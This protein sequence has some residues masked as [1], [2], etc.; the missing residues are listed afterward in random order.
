[1]CYAVFVLSVAI[2]RHAALPLEIHKQEQRLGERESRDSTVER[3]GK[4][5]G[6]RMRPNGET[7]GGRGVREE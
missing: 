4:G 2:L 7:G 6:A 1:M 5:A 3:V